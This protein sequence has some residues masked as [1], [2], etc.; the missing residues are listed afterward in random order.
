MVVFQI[1]QLT[2]QVNKDQKEMDE[3]KKIVREYETVKASKEKSDKEA[4]KLKDII[5]TQKHQVY[6]L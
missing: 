4:R 5:N 6:I 1:T 3:L 2:A